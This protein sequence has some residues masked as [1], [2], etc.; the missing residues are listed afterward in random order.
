[1]KVGS[2]KRL[3]VGTYNAK[4]HGQKFAIL[5]QSLVDHINV[6]QVSHDKAKDCN[7]SSYQ[8]FVN[9]DNK[10][11]NNNDNSNKNNNKNS[12]NNSNNIY[13]IYIYII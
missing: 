4:T 6:H 3:F 11:N 10:K 1:M 8:H 9:D 5:G 13:D 2:S 12:N 7:T